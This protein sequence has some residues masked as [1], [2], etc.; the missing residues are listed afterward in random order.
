[1]C[2]SLSLDLS[3]GHRH[4][5]SEPPDPNLLAPFDWEPGTNTTLSIVSGQ[6]RGA[7]VGTNNPRIR[8]GPVNLA[9][10]TY[11]YQGDVFIGT[12]PGG[13]RF[14]ISTDAN[15]SMGDVVEVIFGS[16]DSLDDTFTLGA[17]TAVYAGVV[18]IGNSDGQYIAIANGFAVLVET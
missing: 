12:T 13:A 2:M 15:L 6:A 17:P 11:R 7:A 5:G 10:G 3:I 16:D 18:G 14:R 9:A 4:G 8:K 1:M